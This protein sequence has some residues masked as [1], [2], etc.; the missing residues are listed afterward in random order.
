MRKAVPLFVVAVLLGFHSQA[1]SPQI[2]GAVARP[3]GN[4]VFEEPYAAVSAPK[5]D[6]KGSITGALAGM[7][8]DDSS[9]ADVTVEYSSDSTEPHGGKASQ[10]IAVSRIAGGA[11]QFA[12]RVTVEKGIYAFHVWLRGQPGTSVA[13]QIR[14]A[15]HP[16]NT[17]AANSATL[18]A[19]WREFTVSG[20]VPE[21]VQAFVMLIANGPTTVWMDDARLEDLT[22]AA[23]SAKPK[24]GNLVP[25]GSFEAGM[26]FGWRVGYGGP[27]PNRFKDIRPVSDTTTATNGKRSLRIDIPAGDRAEIS[28]PLIRFNLNRPH[29]V[30]VD[31][32]ASARNTSVLIG[33]DGT[34]NAKSVSVGTEWQRFTFTATPPYKPFARIDLTCSNPAE[35]PLRTL[36]IDGVQLEESEKAS[37]YQSPFPHEL[38]MI[39]TR[40]GSVVFD[41]EKET[42]HLGV[43]PEAPAGSKL[44]LSAVDVL[45]QTREVSDVTLPAQSFPLPDFANDPRGLFKLRGEV[46][47]R[48]GKS[49]SA[50]AEMVWARLP[51]PREIAPE[52]SF[53][54]IHIPLTPS[55]IALC[56]ATGTRWTR[57]HDSSMIGKWAMAEPKKGQWEFHDE[58][59]TAAHDGGMAILGLLDGAPAW[60]SQKPRATSGYWSVWNIPDGTANWENYVRTVA[61][62]YKGRI[63]FWEIWN[64]PWG[65]WWT[66]AGGT[67]QGYAELMKVAYK[68]AREAN[69]NVTIVGVDTYR[70]KPWTEDV[71]AAAGLD[72]M[73]AFSFH[74]YNEAL[75]GGPENQAHLD[76][77]QYNDAQA[78]HGTPKPLWNTEGGPGLM[79]SFYIPEAG[80][81]PPRMQLAQAV[82]FDVTSMAAGV[83]TFFLYAIHRDPP[84]GPGSYNAIEHDRAIRPNLAARA[85]LASL[86]DGA[87]C[88]GRTEPVK[89]IDFFEFE[90]ADGQKVAV[91]W[92]YTGEPIEF[93]PPEGSK[94]L[95]VMGNPLPKSSLIVG[96]EPVYFV[97]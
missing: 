15:G 54:G 2:E 77:K 10:R 14:R 16:Y 93:A 68:T 20:M 1:A 81:L 55:N 19:E 73:D 9:W 35:A 85:V 11:V 17:F 84:M 88:L 4:P 48:N 31:L 78:K 72:H 80:G 27:L 47:D 82:R 39:I 75:Y 89:G 8:E 57:L 24:E 23:S 29:T 50:P 65:E 79:G 49:L 38:T 30:S 66:G 92:S 90:Q 64:E 61:G 56:R 7:W 43:G 3:L 60:A 5:P 69:P 46:V 42:V 6:Q 36:W 95:D 18:S 34:E 70:G 86:V 37:P 91:A 59:I 67:P 26:S 87:K 44:K 74:D 97:R 96:V 40:P 62:H 71:L 22:N 12:Q 28:S 52:K 51:R 58:G 21:R 63:D 32:K 25:A 45:G 41:G 83:K 76:A 94:A 53:F 13:L 33:L